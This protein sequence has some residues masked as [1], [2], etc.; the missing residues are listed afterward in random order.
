M[1][2]RQWLERC[3]HYTFACCYCVE[4]NSTEDQIPSDFECSRSLKINE[5]FPKYFSQILMNVQMLRTNVTRLMEFAPIPLAVTVVVVRK[6]FLVMENLVLVRIT[7]NPMIC[8]LI[9]N[10]TSKYCIRFDELLC[11]KCQV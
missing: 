1:K 3:L 6:D 10:Q 2:L 11:W 5:N 9:A 8:A 4:I 7:S